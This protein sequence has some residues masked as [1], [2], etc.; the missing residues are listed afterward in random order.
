M[1]ERTVRPF[2]MWRHFKGARAF[3][4]TLAVHSETGE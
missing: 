1:L 2:S 3:V 4:I